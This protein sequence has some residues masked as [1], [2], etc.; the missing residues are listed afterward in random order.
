M[1]KLYWLFCCVVAIAYGEPQKPEFWK[2]T[3][4]DATVERMRH[5]CAENDNVACFQFK[6]FSFLDNVLRGGYFQFFSDNVQITRNGYENEIFSKRSSNSVEDLVETYVKSHDI[7]LGLPRLGSLK[8]SSRNVDDGEVD[9]KLNFGSGRA[10]EA[11]KKSKLKKVFL[12][13][14][15]FLILKAITLVPFLIG[16]LGLKAWN[17]LQLSIFSFVIAS[18]LAIFQLCQ[19]IAA[20]AAHAPVIVDH[21]HHASRSLGD[22]PHQLAFSAYA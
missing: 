3:P 4:L 21:P 6:A 2:G 7:S 22:G 14:V 5:S 20:D 9:L 15:S 17:G 12:P 18:G 11:R 8:L 16:L 10:A 13:I 1:L 19:K